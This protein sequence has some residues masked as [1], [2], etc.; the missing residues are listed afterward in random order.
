MITVGKIGDI[1]AHRHTGR[2]VK[3][4][5]NMRLFDAMLE[6]WQALEAGGLLF[7]NFVDFDTEFGHRRDVVGYAA[8]LEAFDARLPELDAMLSPGDLVII[9][10]D[11]GNDPTFRG[12]DHTREQV[13]VLAFGPGIGAGTIG[14]RTS[15]ADIGASIT[16]HLALQPTP[17]GMSFLP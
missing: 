6:A 13:P 5:G 12:S 7:A 17:K 2:E 11:H 14:R 15:L 8:C 1:F 4:P 3:A 9:T 10:A 16:A